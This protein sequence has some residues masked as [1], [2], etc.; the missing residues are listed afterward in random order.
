MKHGEDAK[1]VRDRGWLTGNRAVWFVGLG[2]VACSPQPVA[3]R[4]GAGPD[5]VVLLLE[6]DVSGFP[7]VSYPGAVFEGAVA[8]T[9]DAD[10]GFGA[11][12]T[13]RWPLVPR[14]GQPNTLQGVLR[15]YGYQAYSRPSSGLQAANDPLFLQ[16]WEAGGLPEGGCLRGFP[17]ALDRLDRGTAGDPFVVLASWQ[18][19]DPACGGEVGLK[20][21]LSE[22]AAWQAEAPTERALLGTGVQLPLGDPGT[23][24]FPLFVRAAGFP[25]GPV[26]GLATPIDLLPTAL[27]LAQA[28][29][30][31]DAGGGD[32]ARVVAGNGPPAVFQETKLPG[33]GIEV[34]VVTRRHRLRVPLGPDGLGLTVPSSA[35]LEERTPGSA[36]DES[37]VRLALYSVLHAWWRSTQ[38]T[39]ARERMGDE[40]LRKMLDE[41]GYWH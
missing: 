38:A 10:R 6:P 41:H 25:E 22:L 37:D 11:I 7:V 29:S 14:D 24:A 13:G 31:S 4:V 30:P 20:Q 2:L 40:A 16:G 17:E 36:V 39:T 8:A 35:I 5:L 9:N 15:L 12:L 18:A 26:V 34:A 23:G 28:V 19:R 3:R 1:T 21:A 33:G 32:L 27:A